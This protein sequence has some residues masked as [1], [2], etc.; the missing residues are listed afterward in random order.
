MTSAIDEIAAIRSCWRV[1]R[2]CTGRDDCECVPTA[3]T[4]G[5]A[6]AV[7]SE[8]ADLL[9]CFPTGDGGIVFECFDDP[10]S[11][12]FRGADCWLIRVER[13][14]S[15]AAVARS[16]DGDRSWPANGVAP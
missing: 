5:A 6:R 12:H 9:R 7:A 4:I 16:D 1:N 13:D 15:I 14:G 3:A 8:L 10:A 11:T 2:T